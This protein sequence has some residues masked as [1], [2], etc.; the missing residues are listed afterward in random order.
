[1]QAKSKMRNAMIKNM[2]K[3]ARGRACTRARSR[4]YSDD[5]KPRLIRLFGR[6]KLRQQIHKAHE[7]HNPR[8]YVTCCSSYTWLRRLHDIAFARFLSFEI[9]FCSM[10]KK[11]SGSVHCRC[12]GIGCD[13]LNYFCA[14]E[15]IPLS[16]CA[17]V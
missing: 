16:G 15:R 6:V 10:R 4:L 2:Y 12:V 5:A 8:V 3:A 11:T 7:H 1:M 13:R 14:G 9:Y 17:N